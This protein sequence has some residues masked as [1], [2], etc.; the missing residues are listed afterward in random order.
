[1]KDWN[2]RMTGRLPQVRNRIIR[3]A[4][5]PGEGQLNLEMPAKTIL[6]MAHQY[7][8]QAGAALVERFAPEGKMVKPAWR[9]HLYVRSLIELRALRRHLRGYTQAVQ[10]RGNTLPL[11]DVLDRATQDRALEERET[12]PDSSGAALTAGQRQALDRAVQAVMALEAE[13]SACEGQFGPYG[14]VPE[15]ELRL[16]PPL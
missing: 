8:T 2:D 16:R 10:S 15:P 6:R 13:L 14:P 1:M 7:G 12:R 4:L 9:E 3:L 5:Q 11:R